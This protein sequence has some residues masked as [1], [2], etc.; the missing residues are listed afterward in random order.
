MKLAQLFVKKKGWQRNTVSS[1]HNFG[2]R[3]VTE[4]RPNPDLRMVS[5]TN[6]LHHNGEPLNINLG[7]LNSNKKET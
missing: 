5:T 2:R 3:S 4:T 6:D 1:F 7:Q